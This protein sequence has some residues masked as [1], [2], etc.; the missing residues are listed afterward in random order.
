M[1]NYRQIRGSWGILVKH[2][3]PFCQILNAVV[4][5]RTRRHRRSRYRRFQSTY[6]PQFSSS[7]RF[8]LVLLSPL[9]V[10]ALHLTLVKQ[11]GIADTFRPPI[12]QSAFLSSSWV[13]QLAQAAVPIPLTQQGNEI[14]LNGRSI[15]A[16]WSQRQQQIGISDVGLMRAF[17]VNLLSSDDA[18]NQPI[19]WYTDPQTTPIRLSTWLTEQ[20]RY[21]DIAELAQRFGWQVK[22]QGGSLQI[23]TADTQVLNVRQGRQSWG[24]RLVIDLN[25]PAPWQVTEQRN[26]A[27]ITI[28]A[29]I[30]P[31]VLQAFKPLRGNQLTSLQVQT[32][33]NR[34][35]IRVGLPD[36]VRPRVWSLNTPNRLLIDI[37]STA[38]ET[39]TI[40]WAPGLRWQQQ[41]IGISSGQF[42]VM[43]LE[44]DQRQPG[45]KV[46]PILSNGITVVGT[47][48][49]AS[50]AQRFQA[51]AAI[52]AGYFNRNTQLP[53]GAIRKDARWLSGPILNRGAIAWNDDGQFTIA[54]LRLQETLRTSTGQT[55]PVVYLNSGYVGAGVYRHTREWGANYTNILDREVIVTVQNNQV[56]RQQRT[57]A[58]GKTVVPIPDNGY[59]LVIRSDEAVLN[60]LGMGT[61]L[62]I[63]ALTVP[64]EFNQ[65][66]NI[67]GAGPILVQNQ[68]I[69]MNAEAEQ[70]SKAFIQQAAPRS[71]IATTPA[72][73]LLL[74]AIHNKPNGRGPTLAETAQIVQRMGVKNA[75][76]LDGGSS[77]SLYLGGQLV[78]RSPSTAARVNSGIA[79]FI[80]PSL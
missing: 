42:P 60:A 36:G 69:V 54:H 10:L 41:M 75:L 5:P 16:P 52:N 46:K 17:G 49:L 76:N 79:V 3:F 25:Q 59:V 65:Y 4:S 43:S 78:D 27:V 70:F 34:T 28:D 47:A 72:G 24:D 71:V 64:S 37:G 45:V 32:S 80:Q 55:L 23:A 50:V 53:L 31:A 74:V 68:Q 66:E 40:L 6:L 19:A 20:Y 9:L 2:I 12:P 7:G 21:L 73:N 29:R 15:T 8:R 44:I 11:P 39:K 1:K 22:S 77:T 35:I 56:I 48:P 57:T 13:P 26:Q 62:Q 33:S 30:N 14:V 38:L 67:V 18:A 63:D 51:A 61:A 58:A